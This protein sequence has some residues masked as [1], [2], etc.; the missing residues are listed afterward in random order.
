MA[1]FSRIPIL[2]PHSC[3]KYLSFFTEK[4]FTVLII[5]RGITEINLNE[6]QD[7]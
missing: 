3:E 2:P 4:L 7:L 6:A 1:L 5:S